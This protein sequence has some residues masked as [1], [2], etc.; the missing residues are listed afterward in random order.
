MMVV[1]LLAAFVCVGEFG[2]TARLMWWPTNKGSQ[3]SPVYA[4]T[5][6]C[7]DLNSFIKFEILYLDVAYVS[8]MFIYMMILMYVF[9]DMLV[10]VVSM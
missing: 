7:F 9:I 1:Y 4:V 6:E 10:V 5:C 2:V 8:N 3:S